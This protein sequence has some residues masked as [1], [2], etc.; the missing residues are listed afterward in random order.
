MKN[1]ASLFI[2]AEIMDIITT[3]ISLSLGS[4]ELN[5]IV[6]YLG[7]GWS[8]VIK[9]IATILIICFIQFLLPKIYFWNKFGW[10]YPI[11]A[12]IPVVLNTDCILQRI[13]KP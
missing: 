2:I 10:I 12:F 13:I 7:W 4:V 8:F 3:Y 9:I 5:P 1:T 11:I 6:I